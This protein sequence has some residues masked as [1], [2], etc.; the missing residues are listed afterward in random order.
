MEKTSFPPPSVHLSGGRGFKPVTGKTF[1]AQ[2]SIACMKGWYPCSR[3]LS[4]LTSF[5][6][7]L[8]MLEREVEK[9]KKGHSLHVNV[10]QHF[11]ICHKV[12]AVSPLRS[13]YSLLWVS[14][15]IK[16]PW[17]HFLFTNFADLSH[18]GGKT[19]AVF[20]QGFVPFIFKWGAKSAS[21]ES[22]K[23]DKLFLPPEIFNFFSAKPIFSSFPTTAPAFS[24]HS[25]K[26]WFSYEWD[27]N[28]EAIKIN[29]EPSALGG[30]NGP[31]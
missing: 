11:S 30:C 28:F 20:K 7:N 6:C 22:R 19:L 25:L 31:G 29:G 3:W 16:I 10:V 1:S 2:N 14:P 4:N 27:R 18:L 21:T 5:T 26:N 15:G 9:R 13:L 12:F 24:E 17:R 23:K 8:L